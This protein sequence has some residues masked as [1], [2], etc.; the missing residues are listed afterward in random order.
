MK[1]YIFPG[2]G[3]QF[4]GMGKDL[5]E[6]SEKAKAM[7]EEEEDDEFQTVIDKKSSPV[8]SQ[9]NKFA[10][11]STAGMSKLKVNGEFLAKAKAMFEEEE[12]DEFQTEI[13]E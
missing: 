13:T 1:A 2:Q 8:Q 10:G 12:E 6:K 7:F 3:A 9:S 4:V 5:Y 11:F